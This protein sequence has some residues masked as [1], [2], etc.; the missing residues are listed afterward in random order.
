MTASLSRYVDTHLAY[1]NALL[2]MLETEAEQGLAAKSLAHAALSS[3]EHAL[4]SYFAQCQGRELR[5]ADTE[6]P[7]QDIPSALARLDPQPGA[8]SP[9]FELK[10]LAQQPGTWLSALIA[11]CAKGRTPGLGEKIKNP[12]FE[13]ESTQAA[14]SDNIIASVNGEPAALNGQVLWFWYRQFQQLVA[15]HR[16]HSLEC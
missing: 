13:T 3:L 2:V 1:A 12:L 10:N 4:V 7:L 15:T 9:L 16:S 8:Y 6:I 5:G 11:A 14:G